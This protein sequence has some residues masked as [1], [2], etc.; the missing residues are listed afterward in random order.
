MVLD[1]FEGVRPQ[2]QWCPLAD[3]GVPGDGRCFWEGI[4]QQVQGIVFNGARTDKAADNVLAGICHI[5]LAE[6]K[7]IALAGEA[8]GP[9]P[10]V[11]GTE[12]QIGLQIEFV[13]IAQRVIIDLDHVS[14]SSVVA[15]IPVARAGGCAAIDDAQ[16]EHRRGVVEPRSR[17]LRN[18]TR[19]GDIR[20]FPCAVRAGD[21]AELAGDNLVGVSI[22][23]KIIFATIR[24]EDFEAHEFIGR[25]DEGHFL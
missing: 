16:M 10:I 13:S 25:T 15:E 18:E 21:V 23:F 7:G 1:R 8:V 6:W 19:A 3:H 17:E 2:H 22:E 5:D 4:H 11:R 9:G 20:V 24:H 14:L 12:Q